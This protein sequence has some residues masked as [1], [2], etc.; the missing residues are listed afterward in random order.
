[1]HFSNAMLI[2]CG[3]DH[4]T[5]GLELTRGLH[6]ILSSEMASI[7]F[8]PG[9]GFGASLEWLTVTGGIEQVWKKRLEIA[10]KLGIKKIILVD[11]FPCSAY[12]ESFGKMTPD[13]EKEQHLEAIAAARKFFAQHAP[14]MEFVAYLLN[15]E[16]PTK[17][18]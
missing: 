8:N 9:G 15:G 1:M 12:E 17:I 2:C 14:K 16:S 10:K 3:N 7:H 4:F 18:A 11:D 6:T 13:E 5:A